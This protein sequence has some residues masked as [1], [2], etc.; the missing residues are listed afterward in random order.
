MLCVCEIRTER[1][2]VND[3]KGEY[4]GSTSWQKPQRTHMKNRSIR[5]GTQETLS[6]ISELSLFVYL[7]DVNAEVF[8]KISLLFAPI[9]SISPDYLGIGQRVFKLLWTSGASLL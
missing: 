6:K 3:L 8:C 5:E 1:R 4:R 7:V 9:Y 2:R